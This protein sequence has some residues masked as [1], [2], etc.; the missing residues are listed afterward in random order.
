[1]TAIKFGVQVI[2]K[3]FQNL[4]LGTEFMGLELSKDHSVLFISA[5]KKEKPSIIS[6]DSQSMQQ[7]TSYTIKKKEFGNKFK[8]RRVPLGDVLFANG[9]A[10][11]LLI[12]YSVGRKD[13]QMY[14]I[15]KNVQRGQVSDICMSGDSIFSVSATS[16]HV[17]QIR[18][19]NSA[20]YKA[21]LKRAEVAQ[22]MFDAQKAIARDQHFK[23][24][25]PTANN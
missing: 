12:S 1:L 18:F 4:F 5:M 3:F 24:V 21:D 6:V 20:A 22:Q 16:N 14:H 15:F 9:F 7:I 23:N 19:R 25:Q 11:N 17:H 8:I 2:F 10:D 13:F